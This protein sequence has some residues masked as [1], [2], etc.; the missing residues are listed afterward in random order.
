[1]RLQ[2]SRRCRQLGEL[3]GLG[4]VLLLPLWFNPFADRPFGPPKT[5]LFC[6]LSVAIAA[7]TA[8]S[9][10][11]DPR[12]TSPASPSGLASKPVRL[13]STNPLALPALV[14]AGTHALAAVTSAHPAASL[15]GTQENPQGILTLLCAI[16]FF[17]GMTPLL[18]APGYARRIITC[19]LLSSVPVV[20]YGWAQY[21]GLDPLPWMTDS[22]SPVLSTLGRSNFLGAY[23]AVVIPFTLCRLAGCTTSGQKLRYGLV[24]ALQVLCLLCTMARG[25]WLGLMAGCLAFLGLLA[26]RW[27]SRPILVAAAVTLLLGGGLFFAMDR[28]PMPPRTRAH[29]SNL[30][31]T[32][33]LSLPELRSISVET[34]PVIWKSTVALILGRWWLGYG[35]GTFQAIFSANLPPELVQWSGPGPVIDDPHNLILDQFMAA[36]VAG[37]A[38]FLWLVVSFYR[39]AATALR[40][41]AKRSTQAALAAILG[42]VTAFLLQ[43]QFNPNVIVLTM[44]FW[45]SLALAAAAAGWERPPA[46]APSAQADDWAHM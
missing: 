13:R 43:A 8:I 27:Q 14:Y 18:R 3:A 12:G 40:R 46:G 26:Q 20:L 29:A 2:L 10:L 38:G 5:A 19:L 4:L 24:L 16:A 17:L 37:A 32:T 28:L 25:A 33:G 36:G 6:V 22:V 9:C 23:L 30:S 34:R 44:L 21:L 39:W 7:A 35:P 15:W 41:A 45:L 42:S 11:L 1:V 31:L